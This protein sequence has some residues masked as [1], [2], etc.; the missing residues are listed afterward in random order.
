MLKEVWSFVKNPVYAHEDYTA[1]EKRS[2][3]F[4]LVVIAIC[5]SVG[6]GILMQGIITL[7]DFDF[8]NHAV[9]EMFDSY[10]PVMLFFLAVIMAPV[11]EELIFRAPLGLFKNSKFFKYAFYMSVLLFG[12]IHIG[13]FQDIDGYYW[14]IPI[15]VAP[16]ISA[17][18][19]LG[20]IRTKLG[21]VWS[22]LLHAMHNFILLG[23]FIFMKILDI[24]FE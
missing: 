23:P 13:N 3:F 12:L 15:L 19:F 24:P 14:L 7:V 10:S 6:L 11:L 5:F 2:V 22:I 16:Q 17:G 4:K 20:F 9:L 21:L 1:S 8:D 18:V